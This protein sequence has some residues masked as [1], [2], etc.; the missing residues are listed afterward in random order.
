MK[1]IKLQELERL[2]KNIMLKSGNL[3]ENQID[4]V[5]EVLLFAQKTGRHT[6]GVIKLIGTEPLQEIK[7][8]NEIE[9]VKETKLSL[10]LAAHGNPAPLVTTIG[11]QKAIEKCVAHGIGIVGINGIYSSNGA[12]AYYVNEIAKKGFVGIICSRSPSVI[13][14]YGGKEPIFGTNPIAFGFPTNEEPIFFDMACSAITWYGLVQAKANGKPIPEN[15][16]RDKNGNLTCDPSAAMNGSILA[17]DKSYKGVGLA[18]VVELLGGPL[19]GASFAS[20]N[21]GDDWGVF[22]LALDPEL[23]TD[24]SDFLKA[25]SALR[26]QVLNS[27]PINQDK[28]VSM[29]GDRS[30]VNLKTAEETGMVEIDEVVLEQLLLLNK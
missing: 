4:S 30:I 27:K 25:N 26:E 13:P 3:K 17:F 19:V 5:V 11:M 16:A 8:S 20:A 6:Q 18:M 10:K 7:Q 15:I 2:A 14:P 22:I 21:P 23:L 24:K 28:I 1:K 12:Q 9:T 29:P